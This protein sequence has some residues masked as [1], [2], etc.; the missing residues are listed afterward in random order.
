MTFDR[1]CARP[2]GYAGITETARDSRTIL[3]DSAKYM[4]EAEKKK[5]KERQY[6]LSSKKRLHLEDLGEVFFIFQLVS[7]DTKILF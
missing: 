4:E 1:S 7:M 6:A 3:H 2:G 5:D